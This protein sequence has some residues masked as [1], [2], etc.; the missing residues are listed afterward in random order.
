MRVLLA[1]ALA[2]AASLVTIRAGAT[3]V[4]ACLT[5]SEKGQRSRAAGKLREAREQFLLCGADGCPA[6]VRKDCGQWHAEV[7]ATLPSVV[8]GAKDA[9]GRDLFDVT[10]QMDG[11]VLVRKLDGKAVQVDPGPHVFRFDVPG[12]APV[13]ERALVKEGERARVIN[14]AFGEGSG[15][16]TARDGGPSDAEA[17]T[18]H[19]VWPWLVAGAGV[20]T[21]GFGIVWLATAPALPA[22][23]DASTSTCSRLP[24]ESDAAYTTRKEQAG[25]HDG[26]PVEG[27]IFMGIGGAL[28]AT[29]LVWHFLEPS[30]SAERTGARIAPW[31]TGGASGI[32]AT[33]TF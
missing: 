10:V 14:V 9:K 22:A 24:S 27:A 13:T 16:A 33:G 5:A 19:T 25:R 4:Q 12:V 32:V 11:E 18:G 6:L 8:F 31:T 21:L 7:V 17:G 23:C 28:I 20:V 29:G 1:T 26:Q 30:G 3:D 15:G 2:L